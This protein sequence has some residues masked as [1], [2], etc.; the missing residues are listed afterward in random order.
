MC[1]D[2]EL[3]DI[4]KQ[5]GRVRYGRLVLDPD[6]E[7]CRG[8]AFVQFHDISAVQS[9][10][11]VA[12]SEEGLCCHGRRLDVSLA[13]SRK[14]LGQLKDY[15]PGSRVK[16][17]KRNM[18]LAKEGVILPGSEAAKDL[19]RKDMAKRLKAHSEMKT[20]LANPNFFVSKTRLSVRNI[21]T[22]VDDKKLK[23]I[24]SRV[25]PRSVVQVKI[26][27]ATDRVDIKGVGRS[28]GFAFIEFTTHEAAL[29]ALRA[30]NNNPDIFGPRKRLLV[31]FAVED[32]RVIKLREA[33]KHRRM[34]GAVSTVNKSQDSRNDEVTLETELNDSLDTAAVVGGGTAGDKRAKWRLKWKE[35]RLKRQQNRVPDTSTATSHTHSSS[36]SSQQQSTNTA[37][38]TVLQTANLRKRR[39]E[40]QNVPARQKRQKVNDNSE[41]VKTKGL[42]TSD[43]QTA[44]ESTGSERNASKAADRF[45]SSGKRKLGARKRDKEEEE[46]AEMVKKYRRKFETSEG[47]WFD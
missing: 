15:K 9:C 31:E 38:P 41:E 47:R 13:L 16:E 36:S 12:N 8:S 29:K 6:T 7:M 44:K 2:S 45:S 26:L 4:F 20:K 22:Q 39:R 43:L 5:F 42:P 19:T 46:F 40:L 27:R 18:Y 28:K 25:T 32:S 30:L 34:K 17:D 14:E 23:G 1:S 21:P 24:F 3:R 10:F 11:E 33:R 37:A 35:R